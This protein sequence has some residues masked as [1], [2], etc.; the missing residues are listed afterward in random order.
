[1]SVGMA[2]GCA[3]QG[4]TLEKMSI[5]AEGDLD[6]RGF[7][8]LDTNVRPGFQEIRYTV[9]VKANAPADTIEAILQHVEKTSPNRSNLSAIPMKRTLVVE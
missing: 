3:S 4:V 5:E 6:L 8:D 2:A 9:R 7:L 1:M